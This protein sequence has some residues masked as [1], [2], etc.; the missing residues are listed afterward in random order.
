MLGE[1]SF[2]SVH[3]VPELSVMQFVLFYGMVD[4][5]VCDHPVV[6]TSSSHQAPVLRDI[7]NE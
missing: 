1:M 5:Y 7:W 2:W 4:L 6:C 3:V